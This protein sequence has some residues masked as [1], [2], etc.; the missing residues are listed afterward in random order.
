M[1]LVM[2]TRSRQFL[3]G[4]ASGHEHRRWGSIQDKALHYFPWVLQLEYI[5]LVFGT[6]LHP[7]LWRNSS[8]WRYSLLHTTM[9]MLYRYVLAGRQ[10][11][12][13]YPVVDSCLN[14]FLLCKSFHGNSK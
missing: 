14:Q 7:S 3:E 8:L 2:Y 12:R 5:Y 6:R 13:R 11:V 4:R 1:H 9:D 10:W